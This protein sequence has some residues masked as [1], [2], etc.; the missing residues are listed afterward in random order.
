MPKVFLALAAS[1][2]LAGGAVAQTGS[3]EVKDAWARATPDRAENGA[4]YVTI[5]SSV[6]DKLTGASTPVAAQAQMHQMTMDGGIM[7]MREMTSIDIP[8]GKP[9]TLKPGGV[10]LMLS[11]LKQPLR[12]GQSFPLTL[13]FEKAGKREVTVSI[14]GVAAMGPQDH[15][16]GGMPMPMHH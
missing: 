12:Q 2:F 6:P 10:H 7:K 8:A 5:A 1:L 11:G 9:V 14:R 13:D 16:S 15:G 3:V 4:A